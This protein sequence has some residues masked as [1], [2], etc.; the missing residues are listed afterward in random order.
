VLLQVSATGRSDS[1]PDEGRF[2]VGVSTNAASAAAASTG[3]NTTMTRVIAGLERLGIKSDD[4]QTRSVTLQ[5]IDYGRET[6][7]FV[8]NNLVEVR[9]RDLKLIS[10]PSPR[11]R[12]PA[13]TWCRDPTCGCPVRKPRTTPPTPRPT[14]PPAPA[15]TPTQKPRA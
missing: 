10:R 14:A 1:R 2:T 15:P 9:V 7:R 8:A 6:G 11:P 5:R 13:A 12:K 4:V 3:N